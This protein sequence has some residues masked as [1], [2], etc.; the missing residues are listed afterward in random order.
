MPPETALLESRA[1]RDS[2]AR[3]TEVLDKVKALELL[4]DGTH[5]T[6]QMVASYF[7]VDRPTVDKLVERH[8]EE[9][10]ANGFAVL[11]GADLREYQTDSMSV[12]PV[13]YPQRRSSLALW[14]RKAVLNA[15]MLLRDSWVARRVRQYLLD[16]EE[17]THAVDRFDAKAAC[18][19]LDRRMT[20]VESHLGDVGA[21]VRDLGPLLWRM[22]ERLDRLEVRV[23]QGFAATNRVLSAIGENVA[24]Q[25]RQLR[26][27]RRDVRRLDARMDC[28]G[29]PQVPRGRRKG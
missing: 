1:L 21:A 15:G 7:E 4:P 3:R 13:R 10:A 6:T 24:E 20:V 29:W 18:G 8:R 25:G 22:S 12:S 2:V 16:A 28:A 19:S 5:V 23:E 26:E 9:L 17:H 11:R 27:T 14:P